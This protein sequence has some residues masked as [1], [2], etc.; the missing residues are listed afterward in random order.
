M[1]ILGIDVGG[2]SIKYGIVASSTVSQQ[3]ATATPDTAEKIKDV[4]NDIIKTYDAD[5]VGIGIPGLVK[6]GVILNAPNLEIK[7]T[8]F[9]GLIK[10]KNAVLI[11]DADAAMVA[12]AAFGVARDTR[13]A[14]LLTIGTGIGGAILID[15]K[16]YRGNGGAA[17]FGHMRIQGKNRCNCGLYGCFETLASATA[18]EKKYF[19]YT[20]IDLSAKRIFEAADNGDPKAI[21][22]TREYI[23][24]LG[25]GILNIANILRPEKFI[26]AGGISER[27]ELLTK[28]L[29]TYVAEHN[30]G[31]SGAPSFDITTARFT[32]A[33]G[34]IGA[35]EYARTCFE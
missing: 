3:R 35:A 22:I 2:K 5:A 1:K 17:E 12:E 15:G 16:L 4:I 27:K 32:S 28:P 10:A 18:L 29:E 34:I 19:K 9:L 31:Y 13:Y 11:N 23:K 20:N 8:E 21:K 26:L 25:K 6:D 30:Y 33:A 7:N 24:I 14:V